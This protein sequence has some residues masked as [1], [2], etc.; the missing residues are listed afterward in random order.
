VH[1]VGL[2]AATSVPVHLVGL[3]AATSVPVHL[4]GLGAATSVHTSCNER[5]QFNMCTSS[6]D[7]NMTA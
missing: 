3:G 2:G 5:L 4:V 7:M 6:Y 1:L